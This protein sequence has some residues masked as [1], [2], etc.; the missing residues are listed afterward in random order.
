[1]SDVQ[2]HDVSDYVIVGGG[3]TGCT[4]ARRLSEDLRISLTLL[5]EGSTGWNPYI[6]L[7]VTYYKTAKGPLLRR[8]RYIRSDG[9]PP[10][11]GATMVQVR[12]LGRC[13]AP[14]WNENMKRSSGVAINNENIVC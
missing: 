12:V 14:S 9:P 8:Y 2:K 4:I 7:P 6:H 10:L 13:Q 3:S 11:E 1:V 5:E